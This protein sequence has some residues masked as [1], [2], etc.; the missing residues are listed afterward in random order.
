MARHTSKRQ[1]A[2]LLV[3]SLCMLLAPSVLVGFVPQGCSTKVQLQSGACGALGLHRQRRAFG[4]KRLTGAR[5]IPERSVPRN[6]KAEDASASKAAVSK[7]EMLKF[8]LPALGIYLASPLMGNVD[9][10]FV[11]RF[12]GTADLAALGPG[13]VLANNLFFLFGSILNSATT[14]LVARAWSGGSGDDAPA[15]AR[16]Q[17]AS[18]MSVA[19]V[20]G[21]MLTIFYAFGSNWALGAIGVP[22][23]IVDKAATYARITGAASWAALAQGVCLSA[24]LST[25]DS[26]TPLRVVLVGQTL[27][28]IGDCLLC[29]WPL[30][31]G[32]AGAAAATACSSFF[33][34]CLMVRALRQKKL[35]PKIRLPSWR[36]AKP[37][38]EYAGPLFVIT[39]ARI[40]GFSAMALTAA[41]LGTAQLAAY[42]VIISIFVV[43][44]FVSGPLSQ[45]AQTLLPSLVDKGETR[46][47]R[48]ACVNI[49]A[50]AN[51]VGAVTSALY[52]L[53]IRFGAVVITSD[54]A[55]LGE[56]LGASLSSLVPAATLLVLSSVD[57]ALTAAKD[58]KLI[59]VY[60][61]V[62][63]AVQLFLLAEIRRRGLGL[64]FVFATLAVRLWICAIGAAGC[65]FSGIGRLGKA[66]HSREEVLV[67]S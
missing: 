27:N 6:S 15:R 8:A 62:A 14:G 50:L 19:W 32:I 3:P 44:V 7:T 22:S 2:W 33:S 1:C 34:F 39:A 26:V 20:I 24:L 48:R 30:R 57:G 43:F 60:Q 54:A 56:V 61:V 17:L 37:V 21:I 5:S 52:Y 55:V 38:L 18:T 65:L 29:C 12:G 9:N 25:R 42:Q 35:F 51:I 23:G 53:T 13:T 41:T 10:A 31:L 11:G 58:F 4:A 16:N 59:V 36:D 28:L 40:L 46:A 63:V 47:L 45:N 49:F 67:Q 66:L 64:P